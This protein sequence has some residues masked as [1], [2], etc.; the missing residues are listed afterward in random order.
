MGGTSGYNYNWNNGQTTA[1]ATGLSAGTYSVTVI[2]ANGCSQTQTIA[3]T[4]SSNI[5]VTVA[6]TVAG[7]TVDNGTASLTPTNGNAP[8]TYLWNNG[9]VSPTAT[10]LAAGTY[11]AAITDS[12]GCAAT[13]TVAVATAPNPTVTVTSS[14]SIIS[15]GGSTTLTASGSAGTYQWTPSTGL[16][17][18]TC[19]NPTASPS[20]NTSYCV[21]VTD[22]SGC[23]DSS[24][25]TITI[26]NPSGELFVPNAFSPNNDGENEMECVIGG[27]IKTLEFVIYDRWGEKV[28]E[29]TDQKTCWDGTYNGKP[30]NTAV[31][32]YYLRATLTTGDQ[33]TKKGN[34]SLIR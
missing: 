21:L 6:S 18:N 5:S 4:S 17:C 34:V 25:T 1:T 27:C 10:G 33:I 23:K 3:V 19:S 16:N 9:Q 15:S 22:G 29:S 12:K 20:Q 8:Y 13:Q 11:T 28:F 26:E 14:Q 2:D 32:T 31:F 7:C 24:C 30:M